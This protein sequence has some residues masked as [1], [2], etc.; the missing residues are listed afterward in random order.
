MAALPLTRL[1][2]C[3]GLLAFCGL[4]VLA[5]VAPWAGSPPVRGVYGGSLAEE[6]LSQGQK[7]VAFLPAV[8]SL[9]KAPTCRAWIPTPWFVNVLI[10]F[11][12]YL[13]VGLPWPIVAIISEVVCCGLDRFRFDSPYVVGLSTVSACGC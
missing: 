5:L 13:A 11:A 12:V 7:A 8:P 1:L 10:F 4:L 3:C 2:A 6:A 9:F